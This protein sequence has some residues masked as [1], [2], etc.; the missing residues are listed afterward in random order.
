M[1]QVSSWISRAC[2]VALF[3]LAF[4]YLEAA[5]VVYLREIYD[6]EILLEHAICHLLRHRLQLERWNVG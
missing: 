2:W 1:E 4:G 5:I 3:A 6:P